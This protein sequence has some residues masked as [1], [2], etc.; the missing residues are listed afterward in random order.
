MV[1]ML[2]LPL[3]KSEKQLESIP[4]FVIIIQT[5]YKTSTFLPSKERRF[6]IEKYEY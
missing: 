5:A 6:S 2:S 4:F 3:R 1:K